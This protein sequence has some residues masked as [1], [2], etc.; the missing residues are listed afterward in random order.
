ML[1]ARREKGWSMIASLAEATQGE[2]Y[3]CMTRASRI[4]G[5]REGENRR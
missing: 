1:N 2:W 3:T 5:E 4:E